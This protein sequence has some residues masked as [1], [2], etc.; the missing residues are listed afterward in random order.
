MRNRSW[1]MSNRS[2][3]WALCP[4]NAAR[5]VDAVARLQAKAKEAPKAPVSAA[6]RLAE[7]E[8]RGQRLYESFVEMKTAAGGAERTRLKEALDK[9]WRLFYRLEAEIK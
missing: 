6:Q 2:W 3:S 7:L 5:V 8:K 1:K 4:D 9:T